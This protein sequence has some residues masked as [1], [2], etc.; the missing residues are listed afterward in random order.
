MQILAITIDLDDTLWPVMPALQRA[1]RD[2]DDYLRLHYPQVAET[3]PIPALR[4]L[5][6]LVA[7]ER[8]DL[9]HDF[10]AQRYITMQRAFDAC[11]ISE[12]PLDALFEVFATARNAVELYPDALPAL[13]RLRAA[14]PVASLT[15]G[16]ADLERI[17]LHLH[18]AHRIC[19]RDVGVAKPDARI[20]L[21]AAEKLGI[22]PENILHV[23]D[24][25]ELDVVGA[26]EAGMRTAWI[27]RAGHPWPGT[28]GIAPDLD[29]RDLAALV[30]WL[31]KPLPAAGL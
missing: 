31:E 8:L 21:A 29:L 18:F 27:N 5:R 13:E 10:T 14:L 24:D 25:P 4:E 7:A 12:A 1:D 22:A 20:F 6:A 17:G 11:G 9:A 23:G 26:R 2:L 30:A 15:N 19:A 16:N 3:W 28:L